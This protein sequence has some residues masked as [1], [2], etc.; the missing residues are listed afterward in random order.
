MTKVELL[1]EGIEFVKEEL[2]KEKNK[3]NTVLV[4][5]KD[6]KE[7]ESCTNKRARILIERGEAK[8][9]NYVPFSIELEKEAGDFLNSEIELHKGCV[10]VC[11]SNIGQNRT[12]FMLTKG[13]NISKKHKK[14]LFVSNIVNEKTLNEL[15]KQE[16]NI[17]EVQFIEYFN[18]VS[19]NELNYEIVNDLVDKFEP[20]LLIIDNW[21]EENDLRK[22]SKTKDISILIGLST[23][24]KLDRMLMSSDIRKNCVIKDS[25]KNS[26][27]QDSSV[28]I[29]L[30]G[31]QTNIIKN[32][33]GP[34]SAGKATNQKNIKLNLV[35]K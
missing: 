35:W 27:E 32:R 5:S 2:E 19:L 15:I 26:Y 30:Y 21:T 12:E 7:L 10:Q 33:F 31:N 9:I 22:F 34:T 29:G 8:I 24:K 28:I 17:E 3:K 1:S 13:I 4:F 16:V 25:S 11:F 18:A 20:D 6:G 23:S 14:V